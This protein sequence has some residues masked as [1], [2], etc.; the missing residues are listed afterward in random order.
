MEIKNDL[1]IGFEMSLNEVLKE[2]YNRALKMQKQKPKD[3]DK[4]AS[5]AEFV[6]SSLKI[7]PEPE[8]RRR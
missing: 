6:G 7:A 1:P 5:S 4:N 8:P 2:R 3:R